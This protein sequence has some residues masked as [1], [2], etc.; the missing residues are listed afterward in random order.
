MENIH[1]KTVDPISQSLLR[2]VARR[3][4][5]LN[6]ERYEG[7]QPTD[8][9]QRLGLSCPYG[10]M[11]GPCRIDPFGYGPDQ[12]LCG[13]DR[14]SM[15]SAFLLRLVLLGTMQCFQG[16]FQE[17][18]M[19]PVIEALSEPFAKKYGRGYP[20]ASDLLEGSKMLDRPDASPEEMLLQ[21]FRLAILVLHQLA[22]VQGPV[23]RWPCRVGYGLASRE[24][25]SVGV[26]G[27]VSPETVRILE[28]VQGKGILSLGD[29]IGGEDQFLP[30]LCTSGEAELAIGSGLLDAL[31]LSPGADPGL[32]KTTEAAEVP[33]IKSRNIDDP[34]EVF[35]LAEGHFHAK[36]GEIPIEGMPPVEE[37][38]VLAS[39]KALEEWLGQGE[40]PGYA[41]VGGSD[42]LSFSLGWIPVELAKA[43]EAD[44]FPA[45]GWGDAG[46]WL[47]KGGLHRE[48]GDRPGRPLLH[49]TSGPLQFIR[50]LA[51]REELNKL[52]G[53][54]WTGM[55]GCQELVLAIGTALLGIRVSIASPLPIW[56]SPLVR[57]LLQSAIE[58]LGGGLAHYDHPAELSELRTWF[59]GQEG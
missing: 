4:L 53:V 2:A 11:E 17:P 47:L 35:K 22:S 30:F 32:I 27:G 31:I 29:W 6:W 44:G 43:M 21:C 37:G 3:G 52:K 33:W 54:C 59:L 28:A 39:D 8:G 34:R 1:L 25:P 26:A 48:T 51:K 13:L 49:P 50:V 5:S 10:C 19:D 24:R 14:D 20:S 23:S 46:L 55:R 12:G 38:D 15:V 41:L 40:W 45:F 36:G 16:V 56:G 9:F 42:S 57:D 18:R 58:E 7:L